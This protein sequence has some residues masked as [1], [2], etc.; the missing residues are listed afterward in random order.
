MNRMLMI[1]FF[2]NYYCDFY[3][4]LVVISFINLILYIY[5]YN[6]YVLDEFYELK[7]LISLFCFFLV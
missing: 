4:F 2:W 6:E 3:L 5:I 7:Y 1:F